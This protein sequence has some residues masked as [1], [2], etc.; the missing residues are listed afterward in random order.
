MS[1]EVEGS[2][3]LSLTSLFT[4]FKIK[5][6]YFKLTFTL[7]RL[8]VLSSD[9]WQVGHSHWVNQSLLLSGAFH[10]QPGVSPSPLC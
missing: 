10:I 1:Q 9:V 7:K 8:W 6:M 3:Q 5:C 4:P 2:S